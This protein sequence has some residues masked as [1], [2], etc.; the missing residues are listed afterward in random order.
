MQFSYKKI[1]A[2]IAFM[3]DAPVNEKAGHEAQHENKPDMNKESASQKKET[4]KLKI[5]SFLR[6]DTNQYKDDWKFGLAF[7]VGALLV[8]FFDV[9]VALAA[10]IVLFLGYGYLEKQGKIA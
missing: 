6:G 5:P 3:D 1:D 8:V 4:M 7:F 2:V 9:I 10:T